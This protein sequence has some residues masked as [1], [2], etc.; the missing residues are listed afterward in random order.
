MAKSR[1]CHRVLSNIL[2]SFCHLAEEMTLRS[3]V[4]EAEVV[5]VGEGGRSDSSCS[6][7]D[8]FRDHML[9]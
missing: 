7:F 4:F 1:S 2:G 6:S 8:V 5:D 9:R 3:E